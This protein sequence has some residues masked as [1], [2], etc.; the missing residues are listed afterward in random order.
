MAAIYIIIEFVEM[1]K[2]SATPIW[3]RHF[4]SFDSTT[5]PVF[6]VCSGNNA[7][8]LVSDVLCTYGYNSTLNATYDEVLSLF[9][10]VITVFQQ[11]QC[12]HL[13]LY[14]QLVVEESEEPSPSVN[15]IAYIQSSQVRECKVN[16]PDISGRMQ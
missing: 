7:T 14:Q 5:F 12:F 8:F 2:S 1:Q 9:S 3:R 13:N 10:L 4:A 16:L 6:A 11:T 15:C